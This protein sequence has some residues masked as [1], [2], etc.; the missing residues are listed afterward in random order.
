MNNNFL[1]K[2]IKN[3]QCYC[4]ILQNG[5]RNNEKQTPIQET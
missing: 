2:H 3:K 1:L 4:H 5:I